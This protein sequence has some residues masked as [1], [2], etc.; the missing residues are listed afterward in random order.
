MVYKIFPTLNDF[1]NLTRLKVKLSDFANNFDYSNII[2]KKPW[3]YEYLWYQNETVA[4]WVLYIKKDH[5]TSLHCHARKRTSLIVLEGEV[6]CTTIDDKYNLNT[7]DA[8]VL[9]PCVFHSS[10]AISDEG[11][12]IMEIETPPMKGDLV[13]MNDA[14]GRQNSGYEKASEY[15]NDFSLYNFLPFKE[16]EIWIFKNVQVK[17]SK[18]KPQ[19]DSNSL[20]LVPISGN[21]K[22][23]NNHLIDCGEA[24]CK[25][26]KILLDNISNKKYKFLI[27]NKINLN[28]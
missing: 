21:I 14:Y 28:K 13:R 11:A 27:F 20:L 19:L 16:D 8:I 9:E 3:G 17:L 5:A 26:S 18:S 6:K 25:S 22:K 12:F 15:S 2:V 23:E 10:K 4:I 24:I 1:E 7:L